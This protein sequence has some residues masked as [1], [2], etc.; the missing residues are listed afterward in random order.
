MATVLILLSLFSLLP[1]TDGNHVNCSTEIKGIP[2]DFTKINGL[3]NIQLIL[4]LEDIKFKDKGVAYIFSR[5]SANEK[6]ANIS[7]SYNPLSIEGGEVTC[8]RIGHGDSGDLSYEFTFLNGTKSV[9]TIV[10][11]HPGSLIIYY[12]ENGV[13]KL[14]VLYY[15]ETSLPPNEVEHFSKWSQCKNLHPTFDLDTSINYA[16]QCSGLLEKSDDLDDVQHAVFLNLVGKSVSSEDFFSRFKMLYTA[17]LEILHLDGKYTVREYKKKTVEYKE[18]EYNYIK[19]SKTDDIKIST[20][21]TEKD[22]LLLG[23]RKGSSRTLYLASKTFKAEEHV[24]DKFLIQATCFGN[25]YTYFVPG[26]RER[27]H[28]GNK[29]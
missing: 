15:K 16:E 28:G 21:K 9:I 17:R 22:L 20:F 8:K 3:W 27:D 5:V 29:S 11:P 18:A 26:T 14:A 13:Y 4:S 25:Q 12:R 6:E 1:I 10:Q 23:V 24:L 2:P 7:V 19:G